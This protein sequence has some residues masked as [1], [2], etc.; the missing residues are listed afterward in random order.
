MSS[1]PAAT[2]AEMI[3]QATVDCYNDSER[4]CGWF[5][6]LDEDLLAAAADASTSQ[7]VEPETA[8]EMSR[9]LATVPTP[10]KDTLLLRV[11]Q[12]NGALVQPE[13]RRRWRQASTPAD[14]NVYGSRTVKELFSVA[15]AR[16]EHR[17]PRKHGGLNGT[18]GPDKHVAR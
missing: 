16:R 18:R 11:A 15:E 8:S 13:L 5:T 9:W 14:R 12:G 6:M 3:E 10:D 7:G 2:L 1:I 17:R 4:A